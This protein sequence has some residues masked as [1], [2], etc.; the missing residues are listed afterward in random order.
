MSRWPL[1]ARLNLVLVAGVIFTAWGP[2]CF[3]IFTPGTDVVQFH[4]AGRL[5]GDGQADRLYDQVY[6]HSRQAA[7][8]EVELKSWYYSLY[9][10]TVALAL[11][12]WAKLPYLEARLVWWLVEGAAFIAAG[13]MLYRCAP[14]ARQ[15]KPTALLALLAMFP[16]WMAMRVGQFTPLWLLALAGG[17]FLHDRGRRFSAGASFSLLLLKPQLAAPLAFWLLLRRDLRALAGM[18]SGALVQL[19]AVVVFLGPAMPLDYLA[20]L[21]GIARGAKVVN[22]S[23][24]YEQSFGGSIKHFLLHSGWN[25]PDCRLPA[26]L[27]QLALALLAGYLLFDVVRSNRRAARNG[28]QA[29]HARRYEYA[30]AV[31]FLLAATP[32]LL[33]YDLTL[34]AVP[35]LWLWSTPA[36]RLGIVLFFP[37]TVVAAFVSL[38]LEFN[39]TP[40]LILWVLARLA[41]ELRRQERSCP[42]GTGVLQAA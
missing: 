20:A 17:M 13:F 28:P 37:A 10:P 38:G 9:P 14:L 26:A 1:P 24:A 18:T 31:L 36:W 19:L 2:L 27:G 22:L 39:L 23:A 34:L 25:P 30:A 35:I 15:W 42:C 3:D 29:E 6:F 11:A 16:L 33:L 41:H 40:L 21:P 12:P 32:H 4:V 7:M 8:P 5:V